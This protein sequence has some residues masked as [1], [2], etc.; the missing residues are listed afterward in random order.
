M[1]QGGS[2]AAETMLAEAL[3]SNGWSLRRPKGPGHVPDFV[4]ERGRVSYAVEI[5]FAA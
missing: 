4:I 3:S 5:K 1:T 2:R